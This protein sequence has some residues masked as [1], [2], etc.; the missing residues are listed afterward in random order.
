[1]WMYFA[2]CLV[3]SVFH[4]PSNR[5]FIIYK[6]VNKKHHHLIVTVL[7]YV[8]LETEYTGFEPVN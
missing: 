2:L 6:V 5:N 1:M 4:F 3:T 8:R 7:F